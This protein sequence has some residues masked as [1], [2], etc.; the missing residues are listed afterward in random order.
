MLRSSYRRLEDD[1][2]ATARTATASITAAAAAA[3]AADITCRDGDDIR[4]P[5]TAHDS[6]RDSIIENDTVMG[7][8]VIPR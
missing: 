3:A 7:N 4:R 2:Q 1:R 6:S 5:H 8:A